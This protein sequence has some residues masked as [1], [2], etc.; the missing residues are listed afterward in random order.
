MLFSY[1]NESEHLWK[2]V[3]EQ[4]KLRFRIAVSR[5]DLIP[6]YLLSSVTEQLGVNCNMRQSSFDKHQVDFFAK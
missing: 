1:S 4:C 3:V 5:E 6:G 2:I